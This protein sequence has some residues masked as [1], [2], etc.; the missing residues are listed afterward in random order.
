MNKEPFFQ[1]LTNI[2]TYSTTAPILGENKNLRWS[3][4]VVGPFALLD[5]AQGGYAVALSIRFFTDIIGR[6]KAKTNPICP[7]SEK[8]PKK[9]IWDDKITWSPGQE[10]ILTSNNTIEIDFIVWIQRWNP[11]NKKH[12][13]L[14]IIFGEAKSHGRFKK[15]DVDKMQTI[16][17]LFPGSLLVFSTFRKADQISQSEKTRIKKLANW[18]RE[19]HSETGQSRALVIILTATELFIKSS[20]SQ[21]WM[22]QDGVHRKWSA[23]IDYGDLNI[24]PR[25]V[26]YLTQHLYLEM[27][28]PNSFERDPRIT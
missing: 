15:E 4:R 14:D 9:S 21:A 8:L 27:P 22:E 20:L 23:R 2:G 17:E 5:Y 3:Y 28:L 26:A 24:T 1:T 19:L 16:A 7:Y 10:L 25:N 11:Q 6:Y 18:G 12:S 13:N